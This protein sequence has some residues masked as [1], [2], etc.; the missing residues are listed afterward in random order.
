MIPNLMTANSYSSKA[1]N[2]SGGR[3]GNVVAK[4]Q[5]PYVQTTVPAHS[6]MEEHI[7]DTGDFANFNVRILKPNCQLRR[8]RIQSAKI[9]KSSGFIKVKRVASPSDKSRFNHF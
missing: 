3:F 2:K 5:T 1:L 8:N 9:S 7:S 4:K 6:T